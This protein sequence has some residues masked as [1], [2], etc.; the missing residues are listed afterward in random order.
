MRCPA[1]ALAIYLFSHAAAASQ[2]VALRQVHTATPQLVALVDDRFVPIM[3]VPHV[4][5]LLASDPA[6][7]RLFAIEEDSPWPNWKL[8]VIDTDRRAITPVNFRT[9]STVA[10]EGAYD[11]THHDIVYGHSDQAIYE[12]GRLDPQTGHLTPLAHL[13][14]YNARFAALDAAAQRAYIDVTGLTSDDHQFQLY[15][16]NLSTA[17]AFPTGIITTMFHSF[18][19]DGSDILAA[20]YAGAGKWMLYRLDPR[21]ATV[22]P[23]FD[24]GRADQVSIVAYDVDARKLYYIVSNESQSELWVLNRTNGSSARLINSLDTVWSYAV[25]DPVPL[26]PLF[27]GWWAVLLVLSLSVVG[28]TVRAA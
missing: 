21:A 17:A 19:A 25:A 3:D 13:P 7:H 27:Q 14:A 16:V 8:V 12:I 18:A 9:S 10:Y 22:T 2:V 5:Q 23:D 26:V 4:G 20:G 15:T 24:L 11:A 6:Q 28:I 1:I